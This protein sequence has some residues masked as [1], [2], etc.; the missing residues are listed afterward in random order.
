MRKLRRNCGERQIEY[1]AEGSLR[2]DEGDAGKRDMGNRGFC[3]CGGDDTLQNRQENMAQKADAYLGDFE[4]PADT[5]HGVEDR[6][7]KQN[8]NVDRHTGK[9]HEE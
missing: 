8:G 2:E 6:G 1:G 5:Q 4:E 9:T 7:E 3:K